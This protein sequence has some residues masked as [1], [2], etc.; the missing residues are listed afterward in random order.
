MKRD[1]IAQKL[2]AVAVYDDENSGHVRV[3]LRGKAFNYNSIM[4]LSDKDGNRLTDL[5]FDIIG[6]S[7]C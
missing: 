4:T 1:D 2:N 7:S 5:E 3:L 6:D